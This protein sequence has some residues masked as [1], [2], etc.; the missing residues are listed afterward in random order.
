MTIHEGRMSARDIAHTEDHA[1]RR[2]D[3]Y[4]NAIGCRSRRMSQHCL[5][6]REQR[7]SSFVQRC[8]AFRFL[9]KILPCSEIGFCT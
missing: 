9:G 2:S 3:P 7:E 5:R 1:G 6:Y 8:P 4:N